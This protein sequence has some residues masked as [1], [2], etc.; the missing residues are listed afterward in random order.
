[1]SKPIVAIMYDFDK[2]LCT[3]DMQEY[4]F[5]PGLGMQPDDFWSGTGEIASKEQMD[6][7]LTYMYCMITKSEQTGK[8]FTRGDLVE[9]GKHIEYL[10]GVKEWFE[11]VNEYG[12]EAGVKVEHYVLSSGLKEIIEGSSIAKFFKKIFASE[13]LYDSETG[14]PIWAKMA[15]NYTNKTQFVY[16]I[17]KGVLDISNNVDV[18]AS[19]PDDDRR[20]Y[21]NNM[22]YIGD[23]LTDVPC[24]KLVKQS[25]GHSIALYQNGQKDK[26]QPLLKH[27]RVD[28][29]FEADYR[30]DKALDKAMHDLICKLGVDNKLI[31]LNKSQ[32]KEIQ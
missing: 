29:I 25:G 23:G 1:M 28:W 9:C 5:I 30:K 2:T 6:S 24:M 15:V 10:P 11:R 18:N 17:N 22:I 14:K 26:V 31:R 13:F 19:R 12:E 4:T 20:V 32:L 21:F 16:R 3:R 7:V 27:E 8:P